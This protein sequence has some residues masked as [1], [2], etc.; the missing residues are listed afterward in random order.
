MNQVTCPDCKKRHTPSIPIKD[1]Y[2]LKFKKPE[3]PKELCAGCL[4]KRMASISL[5][6]HMKKLNPKQEKFNVWECLGCNSSIVIKVNLNMFT[7]EIENELGCCETPELVCPNINKT[8]IIKLNSEGEGYAVRNHVK[9]FTY[10]PKIKGVLEAIIKGTIRS[11]GKVP[12]EVGDS[13]LFHGWEGRPYFSDWTWR[14][15]VKVSRVENF[16]M[17][18]DGI[19]QGGIFFKWKDLDMMAKNDGIAKVGKLGYGESMGVLFNSDKMN[20]K[21]LIHSTDRKAKSNKG[22]PMQNIRWDDIEII[23]KGD[24]SNEQ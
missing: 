23:D 17:F 16:H 7:I 15:R 14:I 10:E 3:F 21:E 5:K 9:A 20:G 12:V 13:I 6:K 24:D 8:D 2:E 1:K 22:K 4:G 18:K 19:I 11:L